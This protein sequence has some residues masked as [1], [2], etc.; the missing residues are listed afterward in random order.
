M[1]NKTIVCF[2][3]D[4]PARVP[5][6]APESLAR[7][8]IDAQ[9]TLAA[10]VARCPG[11]SAATDIDVKDQFARMDETPQLRVDELV[12]AADEAQPRFDRPTPLEHGGRVTEDVLAVAVDQPGDVFS[13]L[14]KMQLDSS[15]Q[16]IEERLYSPVIVFARLGKREQADNHCFCTRDEFAY[17]V[18]KA[19][20]TPEICHFAGIAAIDPAVHEERVPVE[21]ACA[22]SA[23]GIK[24]QAKRKCLY[25]R[26]RQHRRDLY[27]S[28]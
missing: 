10:T 25:E 21:S 17:V 7:A 19:A 28:V 16:V 11:F 2:I 4:A 20:V 23:A 18:S 24:P 22:C 13:L 15:L 14:R 12:V 3:G 26:V 8:G 1:T 9:P 6:V 27:R 5:F